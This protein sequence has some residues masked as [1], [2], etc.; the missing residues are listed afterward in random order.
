M[1][2]RKLGR[3]GLDVS[4]ICLGTMT[5]G[6]Q[7]TE[8]EGHE[9]MDYA[10]GQGVNFFDTAEL[11]PTVPVSVETIGGTETIIGTWFAKRGK[12]D[13]V[14]LATKVLGPGGFGPVDG[15]DLSPEKVR[16]SCERSL[17][18]LQTDYIDLYQL[19]WP[20]RGTYHFRQNWSYEPEKHDKQK[21]LDDIEAVLGELGALVDE[22]KVR[23]VGLS[24]ETV[25]GTAQYLRIAGERNWPR[26]ASVQNEYSLLHR[27]FDT[28]YAEL[29]HHEDVGLLAFS[30]LAAG[31]LS[32]KYRHGVVPRGSRMSI[33][34]NLSGRFSEH[35]RPAIEAY[36]RVADK[37]DLDPAQ[38]AIAFALSRPFMASVI[39]GATKMEQLK[40]DI[41]AIDLE[42]SG[43]VF[44]DILAVFRRY[45]LPM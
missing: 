22:G 5:F 2:Y 14:I 12:R 34:P 44:D 37:H 41:A 20:N 45:P 17:Q 15:A 7:N 24:N 21:A 42:L 10:V 29:C 38:M 40:T 1:K 32:G 11:Y 6:R 26:I 33:Q 31:I 19:H 23:H 25:W 8:A 28:D 9:Q 3:T 39:I 4:A 13:D 27:I 36:L 43:E 30:P 18:R 16:R 35:S